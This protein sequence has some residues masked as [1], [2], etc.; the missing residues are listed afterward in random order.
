[1]AQLEAVILHELAHVRRW[2]PWIHR[3]QLVLE[4][5][6]FYHPAVWWISRVVQEE[7]EFCC[8][9]LVVSLTGDRIDYARA[10]TRIESMRG[11]VPQL[12]LASTGGSLMDRIRHIVQPTSLT[13]RSPWSMAACGLAAL[14]LIVLLLAGTSA[15]GESP[16]GSARIAWMPESVARWNVELGKAAGSHGVDSAL[17]EIVTLVESRGNPNARSPMGATG[18]M[19]IMP[20]TAKRIADLR[21][22]DDFD[23]NDP[24]TNLDFG[25]WYLARQIEQFG[26]GTLSRD[27]VLRAAA[28]Y[29]G[30]PERMQAHLKKGEPL[31]AESES[32]SRLVGEL[33]QER[34]MQ[35]SPAFDRWS[36]RW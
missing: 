2:D 4:T 35:A 11:H 7:R 17:L 6:L 36:S 24:A 22:I 28:A 1:V 26:D 20:A 32:Y 18:L 5:L 34:E 10:L 25:A 13:T 16:D 19:Q 14:G 8:D 3:V 31:T 23:L 21:G 9:A 27:T 30:G 33:W 15:I 29:N 12:G